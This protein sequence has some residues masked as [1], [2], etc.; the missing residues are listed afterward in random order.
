MVEGLLLYVCSKNS[1]RVKPYQPSGLQVVY[2]TC[3]CFCFRLFGVAD[4]LLLVVLQANGSPCGSW[5]EI[6]VRMIWSAA[7]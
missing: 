1:I 4:P 2:R 7:T 5:D 6:G 3:E